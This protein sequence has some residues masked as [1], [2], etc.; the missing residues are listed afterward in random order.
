MMIKTKMRKR[1][2]KPIGRNLRD[3]MELEE[4]IQKAKVYW[5]T[6]I[7]D[8][9]NK[10]LWLLPWQWL[11]EEQ[12]LRELQY[13]TKKRWIWTLWLTEEEK[14]QLKEYRQELKREIRESLADNAEKYLDNVFAWKEQMRSEAKWRLALDVLKATDK[15][16]NQ[17]LEKNV[18]ITNLS[19]LPLWDDLFEAQKSVILELWITEDIFSQ[20]DND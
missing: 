15:N 7:R 11:T 18:N 14:L 8:P 17:T 10:W 20:I 16:Y 9:I 3:E 5:F 19:E 6:E 12:V 13:P 4:I 2:K 1:H